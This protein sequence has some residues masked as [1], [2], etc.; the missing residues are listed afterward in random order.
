MALPLQ[1]SCGS[2]VAFSAY[3]DFAPVGNPSSTEQTNGTSNGHWLDFLSGNPTNQSAT[4]GRET[5]SWERGGGGNGMY[6]GDRGRTVTSS[7]PMISVGG[8]KR[9]RLEDELLPP[10][11]TT[12][13]AE[14]G[15]S[16]G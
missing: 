9:T 5:M 13:R 6:T 11:L 16:T 10:P 4:N 7:S 12:G 3:A 8:M 1:V 14:S 15:D 2:L